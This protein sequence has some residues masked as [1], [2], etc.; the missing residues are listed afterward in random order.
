MRIMGKQAKRDRKTKHSRDTSQTVQARVV[1][2]A[3]TVVGKA[4]TV[5]GQPSTVVG[6]PN[7][8]VAKPS[9]L[10]RDMS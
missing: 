1:G 6:N 2:I 5:V 3:N 4:N 7:T 10:A 9:T 8:V